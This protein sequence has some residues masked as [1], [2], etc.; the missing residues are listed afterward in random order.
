MEVGLNSRSLLIE[1]A[2]D[3]V[4]VIDD[5]GVVL[6]FNP[7]AERTFGYRRDEAIGR[8]LATLVIPERMRDRH[9]A[10]LA[11]LRQGGDSRLINQ[12]TELT[13]VR[14]DGVEIPV[15][16]TVVV[17]SRNPPTYGAFVRDIS[18]AVE[19]RLDL[20]ESRRRLSE[21]ERLAGIGSWEWEVG[22]DVVVFSEGLPL[23]IGTS[24][25]KHPTLDGFL[26]AIEPSDREKVR[27]AIAD[28][29]AAQRPFGYLRAR[30]AVPAGQ[31]SVVEFTGEAALRDDGVLVVR[32]TTQNV[33]PEAAL[34]DE[35]AT[36]V[37]QQAAVAELGSA[38]LEGPGLDELFDRACRIVGE[39][40]A[41]ESAAVMELDRKRDRIE[42][43]EATGW[44]REMIG[45]EQIKTGT[46]SL[47]G[48]LLEQGKPVISE[49]IEDEDRFSIPE[50][51]RHNGV[52]TAVGV[53]IGDPRRPFGVLGAYASECRRFTE[54]DVAFLLGIGNVLATAID[55]D[56]AAEL[57]RQLQ[58]SQRLDSVGQLAGGVAHDFNNLLGVILNYAEFALDAAGSDEVRSEVE[59][60]RSAAERAAEL[61][62]Q[63]LLF[64]RREVSSLELVDVNA[65]V[66]GMEGMLSSTLG[67]TITLETSYCDDAPLV[68]LSPTLLEQVILNL[69]LNA[70]DAM[71]EGGRLAIV[72]E[73][74]P[75]GARDALPGLSDRGSMMISIR[76]DGAGMEPEVADRVFE[77]FY[78]TKPPGE[79][80]GLGLATVY[81]VV[82]RSG[83]EI[84]LETAPG[85]GTT[86]SIYLPVRP[87]EDADVA[88]TPSG[89]APA[90]A[91]GEVILLVED[92]DALRRLTRRILEEADYQVLEA[93][94][95]A[96]AIQVWERHRQEIDV[97][98]T[99][100]VMP[101]RSGPSLRDELAKSRPEL[102]VV[103]MSGYAGEVISR[104]GDLE[105]N[106]LFL[107]KPFS[108]KELL[109]AVREALASGD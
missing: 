71:P 32:G 41:V 85:E 86:V 62:R 29:G 36:R 63:L 95:A 109:S 92:E 105:D 87:E 107:Q 2:L 84:E 61:T 58:Q 75:T 3:C 47:A 7:A 82:Q 74:I 64:S 52:V 26:A 60:I 68:D 44:A 66:A 96:L 34:E 49:S 48:Y 90:A 59:E 25:G 11:R 91:E 93:A 45:K 35:L 53:P 89:S 39:I 78:T 14:S 18:A 76:D 20:S 106:A 81:G 79:G 77:P 73:H 15:E 69:A 30:L 38:A 13:A 33:T 97:L 98:L 108:S 57:E 31:V 50:P 8:E 103:F 83:G 80:T 16:L 23:V 10:G 55:A 54:H 70:R 72:I 88:E 65:S 43:L 102:N 99:D 17:L 9:A 6:E 27:T 19:A 40:L 56:R 22:A 67:E 21:A 12:R 1:G 5:A 104:H 37:R 24:A 101:K 94:N 42:V 28:S 46:S 100:V 51:L 4:I